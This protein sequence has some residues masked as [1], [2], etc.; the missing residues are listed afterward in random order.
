ML[1]VVRKGLPPPGV[2]L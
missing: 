1:R 2:C